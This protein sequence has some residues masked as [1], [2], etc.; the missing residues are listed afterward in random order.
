MDKL[1]A[2]FAAAALLLIGGILLALIMAWPI[3]WLWN[4]CL[5]PAVSPLNPIGFWQALGIN[6]LSSILFNSHVTTKSKK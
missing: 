5:V 1:T 2:P 6:I 3:Q 4:T